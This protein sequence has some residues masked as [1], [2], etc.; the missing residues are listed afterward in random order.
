[1]R[2]APIGYE[3]LREIFALE[4]V[5]MMTDWISPITL[6]LMLVHLSLQLGAVRYDVNV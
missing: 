6:H 2:S 3:R 5:G 4:S 1:M